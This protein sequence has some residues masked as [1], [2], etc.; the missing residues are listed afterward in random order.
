MRVC[1]FTHTFPRFTKDVAAPFM[2]GVAS[3]VVK[4][5]NEVFVLTPYSKLFKKTKH[6]YKLVTYKYIF[7]RGLHKMGYSE[8]LSDDKRLKLLVYFLSPLMFLFGTIALYKLVKKEKIDLIN[9]HWILPNG[10]IACL[11]SKLTGV[12]VVSTLPGSDVYMADKNFLFRTM[13]RFATYNS[14]AVTSNSSQLLND[15][16]RICSK[17]KRK[18]KILSKKFST[19]IYG[20]NPVKFKPTRIKLGE[21]KKKFDI[22]EKDKVVV[23]VGRLVAK[24]GFRYLIKASTTVLK[25]FP[26]VIFVVIGEGDERELLE[27]TARKLGVMDHFRFPGWVNYEDLIYYYNLG[28]IFILPSVRDEEGNLDDQSVSVVEAM[29]CGKP[30][31]TTDFPGYRLVVKEK[32]NGYLVKEKKY[33]QIAQALIKLISS[34]KIRTNMGKASRQLVLKY[35][36]WEAIGK[37]YS[38]LFE[39]L[40]TS[41]IYYSNEISKILDSKGRLGIA[42]QI[43]SVVKDYCGDTKSLKC[44]DIACSSGVITN[45]MADK[46]QEVVGIDIDKFALKLAKKSFHRNNLRFDYMDA[47]NTS[48]KENM[49]D[50]VVC[51]QVY[52]FVEH[53]RKLIKE[54]YRVLKPGGICF[55]S[56]RNK[57]AI[58][59]PQYGLPFLSWLP[60]R[61]GK[62]YIHLFKKGNEYFGEKYLS[63]TGLKRLVPDFKIIDYTTKVMRNP[64]RYQFNKLGKY[65][66]LA[67]ILPL[68]LILPFIPNYIWILK[69]GY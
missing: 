52:N 9:A 30:I 57:L 23:G 49:F 11:V 19:I 62:I 48:F 46:F 55:F 26:N 13:A 56:A 3:G 61:L 2:D 67:K 4:A 39:K 25:K 21:I 54:I 43:Y 17:D 51:N 37:Q 64:F 50:V 15:L 60:H 40:D 47:E 10:F 33:D 7:P 27:A 53:P 16:V 44:L 38:S 32:E 36:S 12:P 65:K 8:T 45:F 14:I 58:M 6:S 35:F 1:L 5:G 31:V 18:Q 22:G 66:F 63:F 69:K 28:D 34:E 41:K 24:K 59:E 29:A 68:D 42:K 20:V